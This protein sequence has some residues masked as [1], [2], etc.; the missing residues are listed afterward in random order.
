MKTLSLLFNRAGPVTAQRLKSVAEWP[1]DG[2]DNDRNDVDYVGNPVYGLGSPNAVD[3]TVVE[4]E[5][6]CNISDPCTEALMAE[7]ERLKQLLDRT[8][9]VD[10][11]PV[12]RKLD[13]ICRAHLGRGTP[14]EIVSSGN[15]IPAHRQFAGCNMGS[16]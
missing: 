5:I 6:D 2:D 13:T 16:C 7:L 15:S 3:N 10:E 8:V 12:V 4:A 9:N 14:S 11:P 1:A